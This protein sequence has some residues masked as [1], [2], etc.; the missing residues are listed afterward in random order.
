MADNGILNA[1]DVDTLRRRAESLE[2]RIGGMKNGLEKCRQQYAVY[3]DI[4]DTYYTISKS[5]Y[6]SNLVEEERQRQ[7]QLRKKKPRR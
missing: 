3:C 5:D 6:I 1:A 7:E 4:R 2:K